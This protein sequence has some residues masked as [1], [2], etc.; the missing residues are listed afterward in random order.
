MRQCIGLFINL[1]N[2]EAVRW[3]NY[4]ARRL[5][6]LGAEVCISPEAV[7]HMT[8]ELLPQLQVQPP[9]QFANIV[10]IVLTFG[11]DGTMLAAG[12][13]LPE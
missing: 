3:A 9:E 8:P 7:P 10:D 4:S 5:L 1:A 11:G 13:A 2:A 6:E 12:S